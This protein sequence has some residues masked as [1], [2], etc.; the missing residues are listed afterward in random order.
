M[1]RKHRENRHFPAKVKRQYYILLVY[2][3]SDYFAH[4]QSD[5]VMFVHLT[6]LCSLT[7]LLTSQ[8]P[9]PYNRLA[10]DLLGLIRCLERMLSGSVQTLLILFHSFQH[11]LSLEMGSVV[12]VTVSRQN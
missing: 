2:S 9:I 10:F 8:S 4:L 1:L 6:L 11:M 5:A 7:N 3:L 12:G